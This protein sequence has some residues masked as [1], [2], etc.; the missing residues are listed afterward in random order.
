MQIQ[1]VIAD[2]EST[3]GGHPSMLSPD[4]GR[5]LRRGTS[6]FSASASRTPLRANSSSAPGY[7]QRSHGLQRTRTTPIDLPSAMTSHQ[8]PILVDAQMKA[9][10]SPSEHTVSSPTDVRVS[11]PPEP[12]PQVFAAEWLLPTSTSV[13]VAERSTASQPL[14]SLLS[15]SPQRRT[16]HA[17][18]LRRAAKQASGCA[19]RKIMAYALSEQQRTRSLNL[20]SAAATRSLMSAEPFEDHLEG[21]TLT[22]ISAP[23]PAPADPASLWAWLLHSV[24]SA[25]G[26][27]RALE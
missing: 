24:H 11:L 5:Q 25:L 16:D 7:I 6:T 3:S 9:A 17:C 8:R 26:C 27:E 23:E 20:P 2:S 14:G 15:D 19:A 18:R 12:P 10:P 22:A 1:L 4:S 21:V 13:A